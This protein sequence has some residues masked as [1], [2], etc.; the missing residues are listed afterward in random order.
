MHGAVVAEIAFVGEDMPELVVGIE[1]LRGE[2]L[3]VAG[4]RMR[5]FVAIGPDDL[6]AGAT[7]ISFGV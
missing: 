1:T 2:A 7:V 3:V 4:Y 6:G 5:R